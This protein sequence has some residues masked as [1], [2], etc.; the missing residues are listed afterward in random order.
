M[1]IGGAAGP[2]GARL[3]VP[4]EAQELPDRE[5]GPLV[6]YFHG[7]GWTTGDLDTHDRPCRL[8]AKTSGAGWM[9]A[10]RSASRA[11]PSA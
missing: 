10:S 6:V 9:P 4:E 8:V 2:L 7:G 1:T 3:F 5:R 11:A